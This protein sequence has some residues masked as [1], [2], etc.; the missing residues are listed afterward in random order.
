MST[1]LLLAYGPALTFITGC[2]AALAV[3][4]IVEKYTHERHH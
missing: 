1:Y 4:C 3:A 2:G